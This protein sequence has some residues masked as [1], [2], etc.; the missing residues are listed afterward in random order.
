M[1]SAEA[2]RLAGRPGASRERLG[3]ADR[4]IVGLLATLL[5]STLIG[6]VTIGGQLLEMERRIG[7][8]H[9]EVE[10]IRTE[11]HKEIGGL[12]AEMHEEIGGLSERMTRIETLIE[13]HLVPASDAR[14]PAGP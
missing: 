3:R 10:G 14:N 9:T 7:G 2:R 12:R 11:V 6:F 1:T 13:T 8:L 4:Y 5:G